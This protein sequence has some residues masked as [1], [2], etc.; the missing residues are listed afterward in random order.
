MFCRKCGKQIAEGTMC[1]DCAR[2]EFYAQQPQQPPQQPN[3]SQPNYSQPNYSQPY[4]QPQAQ[5]KPQYTREP[6]PQNKMYGF[7]KA[8]TGTILAFVSIIIPYLSLGVMFDSPEL[9]I[10]LMLMALPCAI[11]GL[12]FGIGSIKTFMRRKNGCAKPIATLILGI[13]ALSLAACILLGYV[14]GIFMGLGLLGSGFEDI[15]YYL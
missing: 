14:I 12:V 7:G 5:P 1:D 11:I 13:A 15:L 3:Y 8:L 10:V 6:D 9:G 4:A 2:A